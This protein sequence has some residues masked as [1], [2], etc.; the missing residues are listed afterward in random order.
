M[1]DSTAWDR[2]PRR[3]PVERIP[4]AVPDQAGLFTV[5]ATWGTIQPLELPGGV[6]T[7][8][9]LEVIEHLQGGG[10][11]IDTR[12]PEFVAQGTIPGATAIRHQDIVEALASRGD[13][14][15]IL[16]LFCNGPQC[17]ATPQAIAALLDAGWPAT[18]LRYYRGGIHDWITLGLPVARP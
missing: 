4:R 2:V 9:E 3:D 15:L 11:L 8:A 7:I 17:G 1:P 14:D 10:L 5:D 13:N 12:Q 16:A 6:P 18:R